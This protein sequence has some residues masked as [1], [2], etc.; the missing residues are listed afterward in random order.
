LWNPQGQTTDGSFGV[1]SNQFGFNLTGTANL[2]VVVEACTN[3]GGVWTPLFTGYVTNGS[4]YFSDP[5]WTNYPSRFYRVRS[6]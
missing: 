5:H 3:L 2:P 4:I 1:Q 6:P